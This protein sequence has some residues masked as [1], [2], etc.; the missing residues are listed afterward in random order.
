MIVLSIVFNPNIHSRVRTN[1]VVEPPVSITVKPPST[2]P[3]KG[4]RYGI[5]F[6]TPDKIPIKIANLIPSTD[7][8]TDASVDRMHISISKAL[9]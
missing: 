7:K 3:V 5:T 4:P 2:K 8:I 1:R 9:R 6:K